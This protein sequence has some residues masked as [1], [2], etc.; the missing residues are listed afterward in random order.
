MPERT[1]SNRI[2][3]AKASRSFSAVRGFAIR[4][5]EKARAAAFL[6]YLDSDSLRTIRQPFF[7][8]NNIFEQGIGDIRQFSGIVFERAVFDS[9]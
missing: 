8:V 2:T 4:Q 5:A 9:P 3:R 7:S 6:D 1:G